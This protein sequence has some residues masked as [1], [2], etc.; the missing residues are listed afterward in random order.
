[1][2]DENK[3]K[4]QLINEIVEL[5]QRVKELEVL[6]LERRKSKEEAQKYAQDIINSSLDMIIAVDKDRRIIEFNKSA[7][8]TFG[9]SSEEVLGKHIDTL[10][11]DPNEGLRISK[12]ISETGKFT[13]EVIN[14][15]KNG[16]T[17]PSFISS[18]ALYDM[19]GNLLGVMG[20]SRDITEI[21]K[22]EEE[23]KRYRIHLE[24][25]VKE[26]TAELIRINDDLQCEIAK[27]KQA[28]SALI[29]EKERLAVTLRSIG[30]GVIATDTE[31]RVVLIN[32][33]AEALTGW[34]EKEAIGRPLNEVFYI[35]NEKTRLHCENP[36]EKV[37]KSSRVVK[38]ANHTILIAKDGTERIIADSGAPIHDKSGG[39]IGVV[40][41][42][43]DVTE[44]QKLEKE[45][46]K[47]QKLESIGVLAGG[48]AHDFNNL[49]TGILGNISLAKTMYKNPE[50]K[51]FESL[52]SAE[53][54]TLRA[55]DLTQQLLTFSKGGAPVLK[56]ANIA[57]LLKDS[58]E[59]ALR[60]SN[61]RCE[62]SIPDDIW[63][64][65]VDEG[66]M[67]QVINNIIINADQAMPEGGLISLSAENVTVE[68]ESPLPLKPGRYVKVSIQDQGIGI[69]EGHLQK[70]FDPYFTTKQKGNGLGLTTA[71]SIVKNHDG[72][73]A[74]ESQLGAGATFSIYIPAVSE[75]VRS[76]KKE[77]RE[78]PVMG[79]GR[80][81]VMDDEE[82][83][84]DLAY[85]MLSKIGY[86]AVVAKD[87]SEAI[88][89][90]KKAKES[91]R[92][93]KAVI[94]DLTV[95]GGMGG[96]EAIQKLIEIDSKVK[97]I[98]SSGYSTDPVMSNF[99]KYGFSDVVVKPYGI[100]ELSNVL[101]RL[102]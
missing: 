36:V 29:A 15:R 90:Y 69:P 19:D 88:E 23:L 60:G 5:R 9:Y 24:E 38:L 26:R 77:V 93:F 46:L 3:T 31:G 55:R 49:L 79:S 30:D 53:K 101:S 58:A 86:E 12:A 25:L 40:L 94:M 10:Y 63:Q 7:Q 87:G 85:R 47:I 48:I 62:F 80:I 76:K 22:A 54:A 67:S 14:R 4:E 52:E 35:I 28:E 57:E 17:F 100:K 37:L 11:A 43:R 99:K 89:L 98:V 74:V 45:L 13:G 71:Y 41:A 83:I 2:I 61:V 34:T 81:L 68:E 8:E 70:I 92:P 42:F 95:P 18:S 50:D 97:A 73:I 33:V 59:F 78:K 16:E 44:K 102:T 27:R 39:I 20:I 21:K 56:T 91:G 66:Q 72:H 84:R 96:K 65:K 75:S 82:M 6:E 51:V 32:R 64:V 1:M